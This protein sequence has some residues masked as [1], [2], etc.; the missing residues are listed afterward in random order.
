MVAAIIAVVF[1][2]FVYKILQRTLNKDLERIVSNAGALRRFN[3]LRTDIAYE[4]LS[5]SEE[6]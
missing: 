2:F 3:R 1:T 6:S 5:I 4:T